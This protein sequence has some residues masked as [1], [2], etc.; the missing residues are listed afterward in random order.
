MRF[1]EETF[2]TPAAT[3]N[4]GSGW[5]LPVAPQSLSPAVPGHHLLGPARKHQKQPGRGLLARSLLCRVGA[6]GSPSPVARDGAW[7]GRGGGSTL[8]REQLKS[9]CA[10]GGGGFH[11]REESPSFPPLLPLGM[12]HL[13]GSPV[14]LDLYPSFTLPSAPAPAGRS[15]VLRT[16][17]C[18]MAFFFYIQL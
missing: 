9:C 1:T 18:T 3:C 12:S 15:C 17:R 4:W 8:E 14:A 7:G 2:R 16:L 11:L 5:A 6:C 13:D 10:F